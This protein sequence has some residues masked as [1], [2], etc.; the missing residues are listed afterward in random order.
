MSLGKT[1]TSVKSDGVHVVDTLDPSKTD[2]I[3]SDLVVVNADLPFA[4]QTL[5]NAGEGAKP[6]YDWDDK[7]DFSS[8]VIAFHWSVDKALDDLNTHNVFLVANNRA[9]ATESWRAVRSPDMPT[10]SAVEPFNFYVHRATKTDPS[11]APEGCDSIMVLVP[12][13]TL[14]HQEEYAN[15]PRAEAIE[16]YKE[17]FNEEVISAARNAVL[18]RLSA[19]KSLEDLRD[20]ILDEV[21][22]TPATYGDLY[23]IGAGTPFS[24]VGFVSLCFERLDIFLDMFMNT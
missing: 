1:V 5:I 14:T 21:V 24:L 18:Q 6:R 22:D 16:M 4:T 23:N 12:C 2:F 13:S 10:D 17:Q 15:L 11:A 19:L 20:H 3:P 9:Q 8:G 7:F